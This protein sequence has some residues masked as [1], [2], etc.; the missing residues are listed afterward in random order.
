LDKTHETGTQTI[1]K[2]IRNVIRNHNLLSTSAALTLTTVLAATFWFATTPRVFAA[3]CVICHKRAAT[4]TV[5]CGSP[6]YD[7]HIGHGDTNGACNVTP[8]N[9]Q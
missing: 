3:D 4:L 8:T 6:D 7:R 5:V 2:K 9:N 1:M